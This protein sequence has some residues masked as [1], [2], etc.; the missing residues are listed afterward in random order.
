ML[1]RLRGFTL[2]ELLVVI[3][4]IALLVSILLPSLNKAKDLA[5]SAVCMG[6]LHHIGLAIPM[7]VNEFSGWLPAY[8]INEWGG[9]P[10]GETATFDGVTYSDTRRYALLRTWFRSGAYRDVPKNGDGF[11]GPYMGTNKGG[12]KNIMG[13]PSVPPEG[14]TLRTRH[15]IT[16]STL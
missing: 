11:F 4:I 3:A 13:C 8:C 5:R 14:A 6:N 10:K 7:Y 1:R 12:V 16:A 15:K 2:I 9:V